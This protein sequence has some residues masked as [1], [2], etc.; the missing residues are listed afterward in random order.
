MV[1]I[2]S[3]IYVKCKNGF[4]RHFLSTSDR[5]ARVFYASSIFLQVLFT[6]RV[7]SVVTGVV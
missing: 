5:K 2:S 4:S 7:M 6:Y 3:S 1:T